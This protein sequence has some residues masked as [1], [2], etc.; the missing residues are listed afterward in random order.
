MSIIAISR[1][2]YSRGREVAEL[3]ADKLGYACV[4]RD[5]ILDA[6]Q[7]FNVPESKLTHAIEDPP[8]LFERLVRGKTR[9][10]AFIREAL[11][12]HFAND[13]IVYHGLAGQFFLQGVP[14]ALKV[15]VLADLD[16]RI[17]MVME[18]D[19]VSEGEAREFVNKVDHA[20]RQWAM[21]L[22]GIDPADPSLCDAVVHVGKMGAEGAA[23]IICSVVRQGPFQTTK[24][25][26]TAVTERALVSS[27]EALIVEEHL[28]SPEVKVS[29]EHGQ[30]KVV[31]SSAERLD[32]L[33]DRIG[34]RARELPGLR[35]LSFDLEEER[36]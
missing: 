35:T 1:G 16:D 9:Y 21:H 27:V 11:L 6:S 23:N 12:E 31:A 32:Q 17:A 25:S 2:S 3:V 24:S 7:E 5:V 15:R 29:C 34:Q 26:Q 30:L 20:R 33:K 8:S 13:D 4:D 19:S 36:E 28:D 10:V 22:Y 18:R 14:H